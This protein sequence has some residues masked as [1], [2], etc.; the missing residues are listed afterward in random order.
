MMLLLIIIIITQT[1]KKEP[2]ILV[3]SSSS[4]WH[5]AKVDIDMAI[6]PPSSLLLLSDSGWTMRWACLHSA[7]SI[8]FPLNNFM[9]KT[10]M[11][12][13]I[14]LRTMRFDVNRDTWFCGQL[15][16][17]QDYYF[18]IIL[19]MNLTTCDQPIVHEHHDMSW[20][21]VWRFTPHSASYPS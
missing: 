14:I 17:T 18:V 5:H 9:K 1:A 3:K 7:S 16:T 2:K 4:S 13:I 11:V 20:G 10:L 8:F 12:I 19:G 6:L 21:F 15:H